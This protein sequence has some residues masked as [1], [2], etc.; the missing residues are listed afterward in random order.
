MFCEFSGVNKDPLPTE[1][2]C[3]SF[4][5]WRVV[6]PHP[7]SVPH[8]FQSSFTKLFL[9]TLPQ[10]LEKGDEIASPGD[11]T[12]TKHLGAKKLPSGGDEAKRKEGEKEQKTSFTTTWRI[13]GAGFLVYI[14]R[15]TLDNLWHT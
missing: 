1:S 8:N 5:S 11:C 3:C 12:P 9:L 15:N 6:R 2:Q 7:R 4:E 14:D 13:R 10:E